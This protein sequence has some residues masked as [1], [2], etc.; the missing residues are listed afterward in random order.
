MIDLY[1]Q[2]KPYPHR[3]LDSDLY[4]RLVRL[5][6]LPDKDAY[7][8]DN[9]FEAEM[10]VTSY[11]AETVVSHRIGIYGSKGEYAL[12]DKD[13]DVEALKLQIVQLDDHEIYLVTSGLFQTAKVNLYVISTNKPAYMYPIWHDSFK[14]LS[15][16]QIGAYRSNWYNREIPN[17]P[18]LENN[19]KDEASVL[20]THSFY[21]IQ[22]NICF[23]NIS[24]QSG[25]FSNAGYT[26]VGSGLPKPITYNN[27]WY[28]AINV[29]LTGIDAANN[30]V[31]VTGWVD[32]NGNL[33][34]ARSVNVTPVQILGSFS[35]PITTL[36]DGRVGI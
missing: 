9:Y 14:E 19:W 16:K 3:D 10:L 17:A 30:R 15:G 8:N 23:V 21:V 28:H 2:T 18:K 32:D 4:A 22:K 36:I 34:V 11:R 1:T 13:D 33:A 29:T 27:S 26:V 25:D 7:N 35:Y 12:L 6:P 31:A 20:G 5:P 24:I